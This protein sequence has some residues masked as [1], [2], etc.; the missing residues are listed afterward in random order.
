MNR[1]PAAATNSTTA[2]PSSKTNNKLSVKPKSI[3]DDSS[4]TDLQFT[5]DEMELDDMVSNIM[6]GSS[7]SSEE[8]ET[9]YRRAPN[10]KR[11]FL[12]AYEQQ[13]AFYFNGK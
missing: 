1:K 4:F 8:E 13:I 6:F 9:R 12:R 11:D 2:T 5:Y 7:S 3:M 10:K